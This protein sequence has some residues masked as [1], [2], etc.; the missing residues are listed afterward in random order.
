MPSE[1]EAP[2][3]HVL[4]EDRLIG[5]AVVVRIDADDRADGMAGI[6]RVA[7]EGKIESV[8]AGDD[9]PG[10]PGAEMDRLRSKFLRRDHRWSQAAVGRPTIPIQGTAFADVGATHKGRAHTKIDRVTRDDIG[11][12]EI[13]SR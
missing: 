10:D 13:S 2:T 9:I 12:R 11:D 7:R 6:G 8:V 5:V 1:V 3:G 4:I